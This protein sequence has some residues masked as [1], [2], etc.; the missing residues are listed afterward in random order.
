MGQKLKQ[1]TDESL[2]TTLFESEN[3]AHET[4]KRM[5]TKYEEV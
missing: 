5:M 4:V 1:F 3:K 2:Q